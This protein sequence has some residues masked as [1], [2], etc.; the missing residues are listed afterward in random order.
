MRSRCTASSSEPPLPR[1]APPPRQH[2][3]PPSLATC[4]RLARCLPWCRARSYPEFYSIYLDDWRVKPTA[5]HAGVPVVG[6]RMDTKDGQPKS[7]TS[8]I[9]DNWDVDFGADSALNGPMTFEQKFMLGLTIFVKLIGVF[10]AL[11]FFICALSFLA[12][13]FRLVPC[14]AARP[15]CAPPA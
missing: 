9:A 2:Y 13:G 11:Y 1:P 7:G 14:P 4:R 3:P 10:G 12:D 6:V 15:C 8:P 5:S